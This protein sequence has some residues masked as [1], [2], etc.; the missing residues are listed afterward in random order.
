MFHRCY[1]KSRKKKAENVRKT[2]LSLKCKV[3]IYAN[4]ISFFHKITELIRNIL[5]R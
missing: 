2:F 4:P 1:N 3:F 5:D